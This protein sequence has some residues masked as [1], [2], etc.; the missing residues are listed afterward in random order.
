MNVLEMTSKTM[1]RVRNSQLMA[2]LRA[3]RDTL[4]VPLATVGPLLVCL[5]ACG[6]A[7]QPL[8]QRPTLVLWAWD[9][10][11]DFR[12]LRAGEAE[13]AGLMETWRLRNGD[14]EVWSRKLPLRVPTGVPLKAVLRIES[15]GTPLPDPESLDSLLWR[16]QNH[17]VNGLQIDFDARQS[18]LGWYARLLA[19]ARRREPDLSITAIGSWC[20]GGEPVSGIAREVREIVPMLFR[21]GP[22]REVWLDRFRRRG[23]PAECSGAVGISTDEPLPWIPPAKRIYVF[24][25]KRWT[26]EAFRKLCERWR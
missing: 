7:R 22:A 18:Q 25:P 4:R 17:R 11:E 23:M 9:R 8:R 3:F 24:H 12:F 16:F 5:A 20:T 19:V 13:V 15:D 26:E 6:G 14:V 10:S 2:C 1:V 21:M